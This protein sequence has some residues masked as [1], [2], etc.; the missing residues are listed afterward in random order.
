L[1]NFIGL[2]PTLGLPLFMLIVNFVSLI[3]F[4]IYLCPGYFKTRKEN[5]SATKQ[6]IILAFSIICIIGKF[7]TLRK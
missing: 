4:I 7:L 5:L 6:K 2:I 1:S 3:I